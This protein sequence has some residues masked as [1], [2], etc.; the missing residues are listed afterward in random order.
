[1]AAPS[2]Y[3]H[4]RWPIVDC[5]GNAEVGFRP[6]PCLKLD[7]ACFF[8]QVSFRAL[9]LKRIDVLCWRGGW[10]GLELNGPWHVTDEDKERAKELELDIVFLN[11]SQLTELAD[12]GLGVQSARPLGL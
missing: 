2:S 3:G 11:E 12:K 10:L 5:L 7:D 6:R 9:T 8:F 1:M 4:T